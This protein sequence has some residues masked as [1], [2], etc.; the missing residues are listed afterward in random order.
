PEAVSGLHAIVYGGGPM[1]AA[2]LIQALNAF[3]PVFAQ[4]YGQS[5]SPMTITAMRKELIADRKGPNWEAR[6]GSVGTA[7]SCMEVRVVDKEFKDLLVGEHGE[8]IVRGP[9]VMAG[10]WNNDE[11]TRRALVDGW[12]CTGDIGFLDADGFLT[13][14]DRSKDVIIS[15]GS[16][17]YPREVEEVIAQHPDVAEVAVVGAPHPD[18]GEEVVAFIVARAGSELD[19][20]VLKAWC[21]SEIASFKKPRRYIFSQ[22]LPKNSYGKVLKTELRERAKDGGDSS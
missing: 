19:D 1:Y 11:A 22:D 12:L 10:Y 8:V 3:G 6:I 4:I 20:A 14:T 16:N 5:E 17:I 21:Q 7:Q 9:A 18:W 13:L 15:G 2:D